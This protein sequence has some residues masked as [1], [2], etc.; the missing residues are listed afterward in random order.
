MDMAQ[1][2]VEE[3]AV[4]L[5]LVVTAEEP[6]VHLQLLGE[7]VRQAKVAA[8]PEAEDLEICGMV[9]AKALTEQADKM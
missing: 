1:A 3:Q 6:L 7:L 5:V 9:Q 8:A 2:E 4:M